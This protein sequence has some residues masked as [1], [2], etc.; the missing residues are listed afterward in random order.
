LEHPD[1]FPG[2]AVALMQCVY[3][4]QSLPLPIR[5]AAA[6]AAARFERPTLAATM[7]R[8]VTDDALGV[9]LIPNKVP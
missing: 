5:L 7:V 9:I 3:R 8:D 1:A 6:T 4:D 2:D